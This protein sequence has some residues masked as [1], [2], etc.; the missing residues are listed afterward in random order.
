[1]EGGPDEC[2]VG[3]GRVLASVVVGLIVLY[4]GVVLSVEVRC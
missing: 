4:W 3:V 1:M 2:L